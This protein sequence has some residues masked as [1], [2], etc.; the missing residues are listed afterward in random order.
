MRLNGTNWL[1][2]L[3]GKTHCAA[4]VAFIV[5]QLSN[6]PNVY[7]SYS[8]I[9]ILQVVWVWWRFRFTNAVQLLMMIKMRIETKQPTNTTETTTKNASHSFDSVWFVTN[10]ERQLKIERHMFV[11]IDI[12]Y[13]PILNPILSLFIFCPLPQHIQIFFDHKAVSSVL[14]QSYLLIKLW[15]FAFLPI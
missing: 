1:V 6:W 2:F 14:I 11:S 13:Y 8:W 15:V 5:R 10:F 3:N 7:F 12:S 9:I 4:V